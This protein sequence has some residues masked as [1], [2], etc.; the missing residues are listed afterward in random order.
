[1]HVGKLKNTCCDLFIHGKQ[2]QKTE[3]EKYL[4]NILTSNGK[5]EQNIHDRYS[6]GIG[7]I[8]EI[9]GTIKE[10][11]FG[12]HYFD[13]GLLFRNSKLING[14]L[15]SIEALYGLKTTDIEKLE[16]CD[17]LFFRQLF[18]S[19]AGTPIESFYLA[20][21]TLPIR[22]VIIGRRLMFLWTKVKVILSGSV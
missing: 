12:Y 11:S 22:H 21:N 18:R 19:G 14:I 16:K 17:H 15:C 4:G 20:T 10:V 13:I 9:M 3:K 8:N 6:K 1:M 2:M 5:L 7:I